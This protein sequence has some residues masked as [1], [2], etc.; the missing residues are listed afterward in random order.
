MCDIN[1]KYDLLNTVNFYSILLILCIHSIL[2]IPLATLLVYCIV[3]TWWIRVTV[4]FSF[5]IV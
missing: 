4:I 5:D 3:R 2:C 1:V